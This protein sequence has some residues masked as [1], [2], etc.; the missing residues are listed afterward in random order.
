MEQLQPEQVV[1]ELG[2]QQAVMLAVLVVE[3][4]VQLETVDL[5]QLIQVEVVDQQDKPLQV[6]QAV[7]EL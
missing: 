2:E 4:M 7:Q 3:V 6:A 1:E 5:V